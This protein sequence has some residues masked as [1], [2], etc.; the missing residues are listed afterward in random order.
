MCCSANAFRLSFLAVF[1]L[2]T[3]PFPPLRADPITR[4]PPGQSDGTSAAVVVDSVPLVF[5]TQLLPLKPDG[6]PVSDSAPAQVDHLLSTLESALG[7]GASDRLVKLN[8]T[9]A[10][11]AAAAEVRGRLAARYTGPNKPAIS[12]VAGKLPR[13]DVAVTLDAVAVDTTLAEGRVAR[14]GSEVLAAL[15]VNPGDPPLTRVTTGSF[16]FVAGQAEKGENIAEATR[17]TMR[18]LAATLEQLG[19]TFADVVSVRSFLSPMAEAPAALAEI[20]KFYGGAQSFV[21]WTAAGS[22]EIELI[23]ASPSPAAEPRDPVEYLTPT[24]MQASP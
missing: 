17:N 1:L 12:F 23:A 11:D 5:S 8:F 16:V 15:A 13:A 10:T 9:V 24:G 7:A 3:V 22:I 19:L 2:L 20:R 18:S 21:E 6:T 4:I 14:R